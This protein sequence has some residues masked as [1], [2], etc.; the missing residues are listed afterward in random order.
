VQF[1]PASAFV[2]EVDAIPASQLPREVAIYVKSRYNGAEIKE[3]G[4]VTDASANTFLK[5]K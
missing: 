3:A 2:E 4:K 5:Q 1:T